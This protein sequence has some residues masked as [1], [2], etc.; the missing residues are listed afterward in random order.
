MNIP[1]TSHY[2]PKQSQGFTLLEVMIAIVIMAMIAIMTSQAFTAAIASSEATEEAIDRMAEVDRIWVL[3]ENDTRNAIPAMPNLVRE[4]LIPPLYVDPSDQYRMTLLRAGYANP[5]H[6]PRTEV[7]RV[8]YR[9]E[10][11]VLWRDTWVDI[12][13]SDER[14]AKQQ[15]I[16][17]NVEEIFIKVL[18]TQGATVLGGP[19]LERWP[20]NGQDQQTLPSALEIT[21][22]LED[23][24]EVKR[25]Y[26]LLPGLN[27][28]LVPGAVNGQSSSNSGNVNGEN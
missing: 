27:N 15:K 9:I 8:G 25:L 22:K 26:S 10:D 2:S 17:E 23:V 20:Q 14:K 7:V 13:E 3:F 12:S 1:L 16:L 4:K 18:P 28:A 6:L 5:L 24:G 21:L 11:N 19:W